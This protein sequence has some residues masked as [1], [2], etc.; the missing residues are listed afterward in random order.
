MCT[1]FA[2]YDMCKDILD[3]YP[4]LTVNVQKKEFSTPTETG[5]GEGEVVD[6]G[7]SYWHVAGA[8]AKGIVK[9]KSILGPESLEVL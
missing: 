2:E 6:L 1:V 8:E 3:S 7:Q 4:G 9:A 5:R